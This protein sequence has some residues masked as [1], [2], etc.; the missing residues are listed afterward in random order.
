MSENFEE[1]KNRPIPGR[2]VEEAAR[3]YVLE[4]GGILTIDQATMPGG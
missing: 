4:R 3:Q 2:L 1:A